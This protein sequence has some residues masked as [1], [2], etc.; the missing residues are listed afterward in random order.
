MKWDLY[1]RYDVRGA[2]GGGPRVQVADEAARAAMER[3]ATYQKY[4]SKLKEQKKE[5]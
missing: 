4:Y 2:L 3:D 5:E 1:D